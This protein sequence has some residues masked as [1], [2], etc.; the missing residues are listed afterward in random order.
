MIKIRLHKN[1]TK[2]SHIE[3]TL[4]AMSLQPKLQQLYF[5]LS[6][7]IG[8]ILSLFL[9]SCTQKPTMPP[10]IVLIFIDDQG[11]ADVGCFGAKGYETPNID[12]LAD[13]GMRFTDFYASQAVCSAS[14]SSLLTGC[15]AERVGIM[16]ALMPGAKIGLNPDEVTIADMLKKKGY[17]TAMFGKWHLGHDTAFLPLNQGFDEYLGLPY[18][19]D[20]WPVNYD[21]T[22]ATSGHKRRYPKLPLIDGQEKVAYINTLKD[23]ATLTT[24][25][26]VRAINFIRKNKD[27]PFFLYLPHSMG[28]VPLAVSDKFKG[29]SEQGMY[30]DVM[31]EIDW[32]VGQ[33]EQELEK[34]GL[35]ENTLIIYTSD[36]GPWLNF[37]NHAGSALPLREGKGTMW[38][39][40]PR[41]PC[42]MRWPDKIPEGKVCTKMASTIDILPT[43]AK[44]TNAPMPDN[45]IDGVD[46]RSLLFDSAGAN[47][48]N[49][50]YYYYDKEL[51][52]V[53]KGDWELNFPHKYRSYEGVEPGHDGFPGKYA[54]GTCGLELYNLR[55]DISE[56]HDVAGQH[57]E[58][59]EEL[60]QIAEKARADLGDALTNRIGSGTREPG[61]VGP[62]KDLTVEHLAVGKAVNLLSQPHPY[63]PGKLGKTLVNGFCG[64]YDCKDGQWL[65]YWGT[66]FAAL[67]DLG[68]T[69]MV[70]HI[71][72]DFL[73][74]IGSWIFFPKEISISISEDGK[75]YT[76][77][78]TIEV[79]QDKDETTHSHSFNFDINKEI[80]YIKIEAKN[81]GKCPEWHP[82]AGSDAWIFIDEIIVE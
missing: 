47:P 23:Q 10:N 6:L 67:L 62:G 32:S 16:G 71:K 21:G 48:R 12:K 40:G 52:A 45:K 66:D 19:N 30:G 35:D 39:G 25:Y 75:V 73:V 78:P 29:K 8:I 49:E 81:I 17:A 28:H 44:I 65:G 1:L 38:E 43:L 69:K 54:T 68:E 36:N 50:F 53:R 9:F 46:I 63:Y 59:V 58:I 15:Y 27:Q 37:G 4:H 80:R 56:K 20:M 74:D 82:G 5:G 31:M 41:V 76:K 57:P 61:R 22:P 34:L 3:E 13:E 33:I 26:T 2:I 18:S 51:R 64:S 77:L 60:K 55:E 14:R 11:Y 72:P 7:F 79:E 24:R 42:I 70:Q